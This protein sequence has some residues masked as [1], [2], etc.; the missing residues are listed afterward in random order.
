VGGVSVSHG[1]SNLVPDGPDGL[2]AVY[3]QHPPQGTHGDAAFLPSNLRKDHPKPFS[4]GHSRLME[5]GPCGEGGVAGAMKKRV[6]MLIPL[7]MVALWQTQ[8]KPVLPACPF[9]RKFS[10]KISVAHND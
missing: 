2:V 3:L 6:M 7:A 1:L 8:V 9:C 4:Q 5:D 10:L